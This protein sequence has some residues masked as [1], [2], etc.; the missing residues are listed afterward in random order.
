MLRAVV[1]DGTLL[2]DQVPR[3]LA[4]EEAGAF[5]CSFTAAHRVSGVRWEGQLIVA[6]EMRSFETSSL[7]TGRV[8]VALMALPGTADQLMEAELVAAGCRD[9]PGTDVIE[10]PRRPPQPG[11]HR[12]RQR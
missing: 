8:S 6:G 7:R 1:S 2:V 10:L 5:A 12:R 3:R 9:D 11:T 4:P